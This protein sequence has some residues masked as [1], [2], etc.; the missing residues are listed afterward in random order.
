MLQKFK[1]NQ[2]VKPT[3]EPKDSASVADPK[4]NKKNIQCCYCSRTVR[5]QADCFKRKRNPKNKDGQNDSHCEQAVASELDRDEPRNG[6][7]LR[8]WNSAYVDSGAT[9]HMVQDDSHMFDESRSSTTSIK[10]AGSD[11]V[12]TKSGGE[13]RVNF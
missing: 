4:R 9:I 5:E 6:R 8:G 2:H 13:T 12:R 11:A 10:T 7:A 1:S 3:K